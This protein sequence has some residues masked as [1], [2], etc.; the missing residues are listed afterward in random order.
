MSSRRAAQTRHGRAQE[1]AGRPTALALP[2]ASLAETIVAGTIVAAGRLRTRPSAVDQVRSAY[3]RDGLPEVVRRCRAR[4]A[5][6]IYP[7]E[8]VIAA[9]TRKPKKP[10]SPA[11]GAASPTPAPNAVDV[12]HEQALA[13][14]ERRRPTYERLARRVAPYVGTDDVVLDIG[15]N[16]GYFSLVFAQVTGF[17]GTAHLYEPVPH[18]AELCAVTLRDASFHAVVHPFGLAESD[19]TSHIFVAANGNLGWNTLV[20]ERIQREMAR[21]PIELRAFDPASVERPPSFIK[22]DVEGAEYRVLEGLWRALE[23]WSPRP[24]ILCE[25]GWGSRHP[26]WARELGVLRRLV[27]QL[28]YR[29]EDLTGAPVDLA[30][31][32]RTTDVLFVPQP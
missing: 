32:E 6:A 7:G 17:R 9:P 11:R 18:L 23:G 12:S 13:F 25:I 8:L 26:E 4:L 20:A 31:I 22:I 30:S 19:L 1:S 15:A 16:I 2:I 3:R 10:G 28:G 21:V 27:D 29:V 14:F 24:V 5:R